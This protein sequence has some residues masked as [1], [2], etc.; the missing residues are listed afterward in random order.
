MI[1]KVFSNL[2]KSVILCFFDYKTSTGR[3]KKE[4]YFSTFVKGPIGSQQEWVTAIRMVQVD[5]PHSSP[6]KG[7]L[8]GGRKPWPYPCYQ[9][10]SWA[11]TSHQVFPKDMEWSCM[12][13]TALG[14]HIPPLMQGTAA[15]SCLPL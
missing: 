13:F 10:P 5:D 15:F 11:L 8:S 6:T 4:S 14:H 12:W 1:R 7:T 9:G 3:E 2:N